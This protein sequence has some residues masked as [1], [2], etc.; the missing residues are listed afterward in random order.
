MALDFMKTKDAKA[1]QIARSNENEE[2]NNYTKFGLIIEELESKETVTK[3]LVKEKQK[4]NIE[5]Q[6]VPSNVSHRNESRSEP[7]CI[8]KN[9]TNSSVT[10]TQQI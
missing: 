3:N 7:L 5:N 8:Q 4:G 9:K 10:K 2:Q 1:H 6:L